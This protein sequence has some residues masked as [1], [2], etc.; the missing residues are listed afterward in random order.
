ACGMRGWS[1]KGVKTCALP[2]ACVDGL[3]LGAYTV[4]ETGPPPGYNPS[5]PVMVQV[6]EGDCTTGPV[7][8]ASFTNTAQVG[9]ISI[10]KTFNDIPSPP[11]PPATFEITGPT[12]T[13][14]MTGPDGTA[15]VDG[16]IGRA[17]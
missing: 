17:S 7:A 4:S 5:D 11:F 3:L 1:V 15:C 2:I 12:T 9:G 16:Q 14:A 10:V 6:A 13:T 8:T